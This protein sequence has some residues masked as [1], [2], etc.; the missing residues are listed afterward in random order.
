MEDKIM[1]DSDMIERLE[2]QIEGSNLALAAVAEVLHKMDSRLAKA[3]E[4]EFELSEQEADEMEKQEIIKA[5]AGEVYGLIKAD[6]GNPT[7]AQWGKSTDVSASGTGKSASNADDAEKSVTID[8]KTENA[9]RTIQAMQKQLDLLKESLEEGYENIENA[10]YGMERAPMGAD[11]APVDGE[12]DDE[13]LSPE[14][15]E[16]KKREEEEAGSP[17]EGSVQKMS[18]QKMDQQETENRLRKM[19]FHEENGLNSPKLIRYSDSLGIDGVAPI[20]K[21]GTSPDDTVDQMM[22]MSYADLRKLQEAV[23]S[24][25]TDGIPRELLG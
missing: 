17:F 16:K 2:K 10:G 14:E 24:G 19:G 18:I 4:E 3:E 5:V 13:E 12:E 23:E 25:E 9:N 22:N 6:S 20:T 7:G 15:R 21:S 8:S 1:A 11:D